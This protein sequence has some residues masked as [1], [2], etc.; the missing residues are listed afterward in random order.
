MA[1]AYDMLEIGPNASRAE[2]DAAYA[3]KAA[4]YAA[5]RHADLPDEIQQLA[6][7]RRAQITEAYQSLRAA[8]AAPVRLTPAAERRRD[9]ETILALL[10][11]VAIAL[12]MPLFRNV[13]APTRSVQ[14]SGAET[15]QL[16]SEVAPPFTLKTIDGKQVSLADYKGQVVLLNLWATWCPSCVRE[17]PRLVRLHEKYTAQGFAVLGIN[18]TY[19][20]EQAKIEQF[21]RDQRVSYPILLD[22]EDK[23]GS[24]YRARLLPTSYLISRSGKIVQVRVGEIDEAQLEEQITALLKDPG[25]AQ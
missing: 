24:A 3:A 18:T 7:L 9:R 22:T 11:L 13:A 15:T 5:E 14:A 17:T 10:V 23:F 8:L 6:A 4:V 2:L 20:D 12:L 19:Q 1:T 25:T 21:V 16:T